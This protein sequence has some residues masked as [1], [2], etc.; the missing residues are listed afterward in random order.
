LER[1]LSGVLDRALA[2]W[3]GGLP[4]VSAGFIRYLLVWDYRLKPAKTTG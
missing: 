3:W 1:W 4:L 2:I